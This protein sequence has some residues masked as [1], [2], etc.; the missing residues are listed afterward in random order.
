MLAESQFPAIFAELENHLSNSLA[1]TDIFWPILEVCYNFSAVNRH[2]IEPRVIG[3]HSP[4]YTHEYTIFPFC[5][6]PFSPFCIWQCHAR[7]LLSGIQS[8]D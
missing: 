5:Q 1:F 3:M 2:A 7:M 6:R 8:D 4:V